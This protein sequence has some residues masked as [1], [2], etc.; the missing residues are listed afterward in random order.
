MKYKIFLSIAFLLC[1]FSLTSKAQTLKDAIYLT[2]SQKFDEAE[3]SFKKLVESESKNG[4]VYFYF[5]ENYLK[6]YLADSIT[7][8]F[9]EAKT[10]AEPIFKKGAE[11]DTANPFCLIGLGRLSYLSGEKEAAESYFAK[12]KAK[13]PKYKKVK[14]IE[15]PLFYTQVL[16]KLAESYIQGELVDT[17]RAFPLLREAIKIDEELPSIK[18]LADQRNAELY[19]VAGDVYLLAK[20]G[21]NAVKNYSRAGELDP[22]SPDAKVKQGNMYLR[23]E[24]LDAAIPLFEDAKKIDENFAPVYQELGGLYTLAGRN[25]KAKENYKKFLGLSGNSTP[26]RLRYIQSLYKSRDYEGTIIEIEDMFDKTPNTKTLYNNLNRLAAYSYF[27]KGIKLERDKKT[28]ESLKDYSKSQTYLEFFFKNVAEGKTISKDFT[29]YGKTILKQHTNFP[30]L[31][32]DTTKLRSEKAKIEKNLADAKDKDKKKE[33]TLKAA[34]KSKVDS[35]QAI[36]DSK[37]P[38]LQQEDAIIEK[39]FA[40]LWKAYE[41]DKEDKDKNL[42]AIYSLAYFT[43]KRYDEAAKAQEVIISRKTPDVNDYLTLGKAYYQGKNYSK[44]LTNF[45]KVIETAPK[46]PLGYL[47][48][49]N[50]CS[51]M[52]PDSKQGLAKPHYEKLIEVS[53]ADTVKYKSHLSTAYGYLASYY[54]FAEKDKGKDLTKAKENYFRMIYLDPKDKDTQVRAWIGLGYLYFT[55]EKNYAKSQDAFENVLKLDPANNTAKKSLEALSKIKK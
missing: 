10:A 45:D 32:Q 55:E 50:T 38:K 53:L 42:D 51:G 46:D 37:L 48:K 21:S 2:K 18:K 6:Q 19:L 16:A 52:D 33:E 36:I 12:A 1:L 15:K 28:E 22:K 34:L 43:Y 3:A 54:H 31:Q 9:R 4:N 27:E 40:Q 11:A 25:A 24:N 49:A 20:D 5:G 30:K 7:F 23:A 17:S 47:W 29:Y 35:M 41:M 8:S 14:Q 13:L 26:A 39:G 44:A